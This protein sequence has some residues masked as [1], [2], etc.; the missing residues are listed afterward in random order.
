MVHVFTHFVSLDTIENSIQ[1]LQK[2]EEYIVQRYGGIITDVIC[3][4]IAKESKRNTQSYNGLSKS[5]LL[6]II[7]DSFYVDRFDID[8]SQDRTQGDTLVTILER[9]KIHQSY[10]KNMEFPLIVTALSTERHCD[11]FPMK[12][13]VF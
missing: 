1:V 7:V 6:G 13:N 8:R 5:V 3:E 12:C 4:T 10:F 11:Y 2:A 9:A